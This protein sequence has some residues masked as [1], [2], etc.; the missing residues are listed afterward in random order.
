MKDTPFSLDTLYDVPAAI[1]VNSWLTKLDDKS[2]YDHVFMTEA[3]RDFLGFQWGG[4]YFRCNTLPFGWKNSAF[5]YHTINLAAMSFL[6]T[7]AISGLIYIDD[8]LIEEYR[9]TLTRSCDSPFNRSDIAI[10]FAVKV[11]G[12]LGYFINT[13]KS[14][15]IPCKRLTFLGLEIATQDASFYVPN[16]RKLKIATVRE[17]ILSND[18]VPTRTIKK[19]TGFVCQQFLRFRVQNSS[20]RCEIG[21]YLRLSLPSIHIFM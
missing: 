20:R 21:L 3:S 10:R 11:L 12:D 17:Y 19:F 18:K 2:G 6:R 9:G 15:L 16:K 5:V 1:K 13:S 8:R 4:H 14:V 7:R